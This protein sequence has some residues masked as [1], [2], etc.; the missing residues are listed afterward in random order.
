MIYDLY[1][2]R[3]Q[4]ESFQKKSFTALAREGLVQSDDSSCALAAAYTLEGGLTINQL[5]ESER[6]LE[7]YEASL[8]T[9]PQFAVYYSQLAAEGQL[10][11][12]EILSGLVQQEPGVNC[13]TRYWPALCL[14]EL[15]SLTQK[16]FISWEVNSEGRT[17]LVRVRT[18]ERVPAAL[19]ACILEDFQ[20]LKFKKK[21]RKSR[22]QVSLQLKAASLSIPRSAGR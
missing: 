21:R 4:R 18:D 22:A 6:A 19:E 11:Q 5:A 15:E 7:R 16:F 10:S 9:P 14:E 17:E 13:V 8:A 20:H 1:L 12:P 3:A 2:S